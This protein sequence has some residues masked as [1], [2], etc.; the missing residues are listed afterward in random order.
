M[1]ILKGKFLQPGIRNPSSLAKARAVKQAKAVKGKQIRKG[2][3]KMSS[4]VD[5]SVHK[6]Y[7]GSKTDKTFLELISFP[8]LEI[9][10]RK[11]Y[12]ISPH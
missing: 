12:C 8:K 9:Q 10:M 11:S 7:K 6:N 5:D 1:L 2:W 3:I 4:F